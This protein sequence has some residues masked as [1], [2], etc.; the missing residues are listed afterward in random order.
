M[1]APLESTCLFLIFS[2][3]NRFLDCLNWRNYIGDTVSARYLRKRMN[4]KIF[5]RPT[6]N[7]P[8]VH[9]RIS[10]ELPRVLHSSI[11]LA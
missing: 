10:E 8:A 11:S 3:L 7:Y 4:I 6:D 9:Q 2:G 1:S 5:P